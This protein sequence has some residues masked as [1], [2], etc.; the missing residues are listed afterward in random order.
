MLSQ[1]AIEPAFEQDR[2]V[3][4]IRQQLAAAGRERLVLGLSGGIDSSLAAAL[5]VRAVGAENVRGMIMPY[6]SS[7][8][9]SENHA[10]LLAEQLEIKCLRFDISAMVDA[11]E[12]AF[13]DIDARRR[14]NIM[15]RCRMIAL[16]DQTEAFCGLGMGT[17]NR[18]ETLLGYFTI[19][20][21]GV[22]AFRPISHLYKC[23]VRALARHMGVP[24][25]IIDKAPSADLWAGQTDED[26]LGFSYD[27]ADQVLYLLTEEHLSPTQVAEYG[28]APNVVQA[29]QRKMAATAFK[30]R[31]P[32]SL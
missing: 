13:P 11:I 29:V 18:T 3:R 6:R 23:Q 5:S 9:D 20:G 24:A 22:A 27:T 2:I 31:L 17:S 4:F 14:G 25:M 10:R 19:H 7:N 30:R 28:F 26:E 16:F 21:D 15:A 32:P 12:S 1:L 8:P